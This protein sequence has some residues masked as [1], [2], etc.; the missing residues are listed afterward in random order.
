M[1]KFVLMILTYSIT[2]HAQ[3]V[4]LDR[5][6]YIQKAERFNFEDTYREITLKSALEQGL[7][8]NYNQKIRKLKN[9][10]LEIA[11]SDAKSSFWLPKF[12]LSLT[13]DDHK[14]GSLYNG[15][16]NA[17][18]SSTNSFGTLALGFE[19]FTLFNWGIDHLSY[20]NDISG[21]KRGQEILSEQERD[22]KHSLII[23]FFEIEYSKSIEVIKKTQLRHASYIYRLNREKVKLRKVSKQEYLQARNE[24]LKAQSEYYQ[25]RKNSQVIDDQMAA[26]VGDPTGT[27]YVLTE[28]L[29]YQKLSTTAEVAFQ[30]AHKNNPTVLNAITSLEQ[31]KRSYQITVREDLPLPKFSLN[32]G[33]Y[34]HSF[35]DD[36]N[37][38]RFE[39]APGDSNI[40]LS[41]SINATWTIWGE[42]GFLNSRKKAKS[43]IN[44]Y[45]SEKELQQAKFNLKSQIKQIFRKILNYQ[46]DL[47]ILNARVVTLRKLFDTILESYMNRKTSFINYIQ[48]LRDLTLTDEAISRTYFQHTQSKILLAQT[49]GV[50]DFVGENFENL[51]VKEIQK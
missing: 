20:Q 49:M 7:R 28:K 19:D 24:F 14:V 5:E 30:I 12:A 17:T 41:A 33:A 51:A 35:G 42:N 22:L 44:K 38:T 26:L 6:A 3:K 18:P 45:I 46:N 43:M 47:E 11:L 50:E 32:L 13:T 21:Y 8:K 2:C 34:K 25:A 10:Q 27:R 29:S 36:N 37:Q 9:E 39:T 4:Q 40:D 1:F 15:S 31:A 16:R 23:K 48:T